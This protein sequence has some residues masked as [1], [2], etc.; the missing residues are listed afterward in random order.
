MSTNHQFIAFDQQ[1][2]KRY[3]KTTSSILTGY[4]LDPYRPENRIDWLLSS[5]N[6]NFQVVWE[7]GQTP[8]LI[9]TGFSYDDEVIELYS[10]TEVRLFERAN[11][12]AIENGA[13]KLY[14]EDAPAVDMTNFMTDDEVEA[15]ATTKQI[16]S[17]KKKIAGVY[18]TLTLKRILEAVE[19]HDRPMSV[20]KAIKE[21][22]DEL[23]TNN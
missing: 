6:A 3:A 20:A 23:S 11:R 10:D 8:R 16:P 22:I 5:P 2:V 19:K 18:S 1:I 7:E 13:L 15:I 14:T 9:R 12:A 17:I 21:R 4:R